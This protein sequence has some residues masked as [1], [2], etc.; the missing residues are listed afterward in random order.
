[1]DHEKTASTDRAQALDSAL[2]EALSGI[3]MRAAELATDPATQVELLTARAEHY[4]GR[5]PDALRPRLLELLDDRIAAGPGGLRG[6]REH[7]RL[8]MLRHELGVLSR[9]G[10][11]LPVDGYIDTASAS[12]MPFQP[13]PTALIYPLGTSRTVTEHPECGTRR[14]AR[15][16]TACAV[17]LGGG[18]TVLALA[19]G[20]P[21][22]V[23]LVLAALG[24]LGIGWSLHKLRRALLGPTEISRVET[25]L[26]E[27]RPPV[28]AI[29][30]Y[31]AELD[32]PEHADRISPVRVQAVR[33]S[34]IHYGAEHAGQYWSQTREQFADNQRLA[35]MVS[36]AQADQRRDAIQSRSP[37]LQELLHQAWVLER[38]LDAVAE[39]TDVPHAAITR[40]T[41][42]RAQAVEHHR[43]QLARITAEIDQ[44]AIEA[45]KLEWMTAH[46]RTM[47]EHLKLD[48][49]MGTSRRFDA[50]LLKLIGR[51]GSNNR[52]NGISDDPGYHHDEDM[53]VDELDGAAAEIEAIVGFTAHTPY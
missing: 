16:K 6:L 42:G 44:C 32:A 17:L 10:Y 35:A 31:C 48:L 20:A 50:S 27:H 39:H 41:S 18:A 45:V 2:S 43:G 4:R 52:T 33:L 49:A 47:V 9:R 46:L 28:R 8:R 38:E 13:V 26:R 19:L 11:D 40:S 1:M 34:L 30:E 15:V 5:S 25:L 24:G 23:T 12:V 21:A 29:S 14:A 36:L 3:D 51:G 22:A 53:L 37:V 7:L